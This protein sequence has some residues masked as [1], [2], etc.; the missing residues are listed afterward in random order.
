[1]QL[2]VN[3]YAYVFVSLDHRY[4]IRDFVKCLAEVKLS[5]NF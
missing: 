1:M 4:F 2:L 3:I 5:L